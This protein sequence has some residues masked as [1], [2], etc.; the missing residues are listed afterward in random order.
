MICL[1]YYAPYVSGEVVLSHEDADF[2][3]VTY[4]EVIVLD[5]IEGIIDEI[6]M[7]NKILN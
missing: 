2:A 7:V 6:G 5:F 1:S 4:D 3:W